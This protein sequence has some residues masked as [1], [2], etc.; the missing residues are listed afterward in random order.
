MQPLLDATGLVLGLHRL[1]HAAPVA[2]QGRRQFGPSGAGTF[3]ASVVCLDARRQ[4]RI[5]HRPA[6][7]HQGLHAAFAARLQGVL[8]GPDLP[9]GHQRQV[10]QGR[11]DA[12]QLVPVGRRLVAVALR[13]RMHHQ[14]RRAARGERLRGLEH[15]TTVLHAQAHL[16]GDGDTLRHRA[17]HR[18]DDAVQQLG[19]VEQHGAA[20]VP[21]DAAG[22]AAE[23]QVDARWRQLGQ[24]RRVVGQHRRVGAEQL[25][26]H[27]HAGLGAP[28]G[29]QLG[30]DAREHA[31]GQHA[32]GDADELADG[33]RVG[34]QRRQLLAQ[35]VIEQA[36]HGR[37]QQR[38]KWRQVLHRNC[39]QVRE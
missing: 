2:E 34:R 25:R 13:A 22:R 11:A 15:A 16:G 5:G 7:Q 23:V 6:P 35:Q 36:L 33:H 39:G 30:H 19:F 8:Q 27:R 17:A 31:L 29:Q 20:S 28:A 38:R 32:V 14:L 10:G 26:P 9:V 1:A 21:V 3:K 18:R 12:R 24:A 37:Q 4:P